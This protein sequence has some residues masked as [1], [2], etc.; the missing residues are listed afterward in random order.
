MSCPWRERRLSAGVA[1]SPAGARSLW[2]LRE[3]WV[4]V[5]SA[6]RLDRELSCCV[7]GPRSLIGLEALARQPLRLRV[8]TLSTVRLCTIEIAAFHDWVGD[9]GGPVATVLDCAVE[10]V[11]RRAVEREGLSGTALVRLARFLVRSIPAREGPERPLELKALVLARVLAMRPETLSRA[12]S[13]LRGRGVMGPGRDLSILD[14]EALAAIA[15]EPLP[16]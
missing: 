14:P 10:E 2:Y 6:D 5:S 15:G 16:P 8:W 11:V 3:G 1:V 12:L 4:V 9:S 13:E 7:R